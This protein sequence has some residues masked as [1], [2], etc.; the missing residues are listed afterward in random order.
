MIALEITA[1]TLIILVFLS[2]QADLYIKRGEVKE[3]SLSLTIFTYPLDRG[4]RNKKKKKM[5]L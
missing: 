3:L 4:K 5:H 2:Q 1:I